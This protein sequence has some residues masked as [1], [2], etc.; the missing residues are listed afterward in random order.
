MKLLIVAAYSQYKIM[1]YLPLP[2]YTRRSILSKKK[3]KMISYVA[4]AVSNRKRPSG[5]SVALPEMTAEVVY[6]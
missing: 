1:Q 6:V 3:K 5:G 2:A 4:V